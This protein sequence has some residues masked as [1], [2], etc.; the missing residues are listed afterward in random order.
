MV[1]IEP[2]NAMISLLGGLAAGA[3][4]ITGLGKRQRDEWREKRRNLN[5]LN[6]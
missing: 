3:W 2:T 4:R 5:W 6:I 1:D